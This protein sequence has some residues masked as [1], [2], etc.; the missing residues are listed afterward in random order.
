MYTGQRVSW[1]L[2][3]PMEAITMSIYCIFPHL[4]SQIILLMLY[5]RYLRA[6]SYDPQAAY[7]QYSTSAAWRRK[8]KLDE[9][10][11]NAE[12][13]RFGRMNRVVSHSPTSTLHLNT[14]YTL[15]SH[16]HTTSNRSGPAA[17]TKRASH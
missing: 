17:A 2:I 10:Y 3:Q 11:D 5:R 13:Q 8:H 12:I 16:L 4:T 1:K 15:S 14:T 6:R 9:T 7:E